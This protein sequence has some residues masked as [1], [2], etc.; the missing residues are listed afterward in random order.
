[1]CLALCQLDIIYILLSLSVSQAAEEGIVEG[2][3]RAG[4]MLYEGEG[5]EK[6]PSFARVYLQNAAKKVHDE[7][8]F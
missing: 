1:M 6:D 5:G 8:N 2:M 7:L 4:I 3:T